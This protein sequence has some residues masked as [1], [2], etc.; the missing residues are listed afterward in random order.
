VPVLVIMVTGLLVSTVYL[1][2]HYIVDLIA[3]AA[4]VPWVL[5]ATPRFDRWW[6][7]GAGGR[8]RADASVGRP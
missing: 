8:D 4:L 3:G 2:H 7:G 5:W 6:Q 1:R